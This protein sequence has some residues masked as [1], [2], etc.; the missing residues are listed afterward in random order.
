MSIS[1]QMGQEQNVASTE[2]FTPKTNPTSLAIPTKMP[3]A[4]EKSFN[5]GSWLD[6]RKQAVSSTKTT[7]KTKKIKKSA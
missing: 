3:L 5:L 1:F 4:K 2:L 7:K 6:S